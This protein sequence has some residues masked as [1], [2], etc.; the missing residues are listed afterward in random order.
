MKEKSERNTKRILA[1][2]LIIAILVG[3][4]AM[5]VVPIVVATSW[6]NTTLEKHQQDL[7]TYS[8]ETYDYLFKSV[9]Q[10]FREDEWIIDINA[11]PDD[12]VIEKIEMQGDGK[13]ICKLYKK[14]EQKKY[15]P[16][17]N[18]NADLSQHFEILSTSSPYASEEEFVKAFKANIKNSATAKAYTTFIIEVFALIILLYIPYGITSIRKNYKRTFQ[19]KK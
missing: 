14:G 7:E 13:F 1:N 11:K 8:Y 6:Y 10:I 9:S 16:D 3:I 18:I 12:I 19:Q 17:E 15:F 5:I 4:I 2:L